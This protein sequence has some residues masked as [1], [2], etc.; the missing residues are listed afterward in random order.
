MP[1]CRQTLLEAPPGKLPLD[2][3]KHTD[4]F[5]K[6]KMCKFHIMGLCSKGQGCL[7]AHGKEELAPLPDL[8]RTKLC[9]TLIN[10]GTCEEPDCKF[11]HNKEELRTAASIAR[12]PSNSQPDAPEHGARA[13]IGQEFD[14]VRLEAFQPLTGAS[15]AKK[16]RKPHDKRAARQT[17]ALQFQNEEQQPLR[18]QQQLM[19][20]QQQEQQPQQQQHQKLQLQEQ[21]KL[22]QQNEELLRTQ[23]DLQRFLQQQEVLLQQHQQHLQQQQQ[24]EQQQHQQQQQQQQQQLQQQQQQQQQRQQHQQQEQRQQQQQK[25]KRNKHNEKQL[26]KK[27][28]PEKHGEEQ[29][30]K[31]ADIQVQGSQ[32][33]PTTAAATYEAGLPPGR[34]VQSSTGMA[35]MWGIAQIPAGMYPA[36]AMLQATPVAVS[37]VPGTAAAYA[38]VDAGQLQANSNRFDSNR[39]GGSSCSSSSDTEHCGSQNVGSFGSNLTETPPPSYL[40]TGP[41]NCGAGMAKAQSYEMA[42]LADDSQAECWSS[43]NQAEATAGHPNGAYVFVEQYSEQRPP[44]VMGLA[45]MIGSG[46]C[47][48]KNTFLNFQPRGPRLRSVVSA[49]GLVHLGGEA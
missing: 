9:K 7:F 30:F 1:R 20:Q 34:V 10:T 14:K 31:E 22:Q 6:T 26:Y 47:M 32:A 33:L 5:Q 21:Q 18:Q 38:L 4:I 46:D 49:D 37:C 36:P 27:L 39:F 2:P 40:Y 15:K 48:V 29:H 19:L 41:G 17:D 45:E 13:G 28:Q 25:P 16:A 3:M 8:F 43:V 44:Q 12:H 23:Q 42:P 11:A 35:P 24:D